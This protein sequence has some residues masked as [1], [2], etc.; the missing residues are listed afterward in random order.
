[1]L[2]PGE[3]GNDVFLQSCAD[4]IYAD[5]DFAKWRA[6]GR[7]PD[8]GN[9]EPKDRVSTAMKNGL[10]IATAILCVAGAA[11]SAVSLQNHFSASQTGYC[12]LN[13]IFNCDLVNRSIY[14]RFMG[15]PVALIGLVGYLLLGGLTVF[16]GRASDRM[17]L[18][19][20]FAGL[21]F[22]SYLAYIEARVLAVWCILCIGSLIAI[23][24]IFILSVFGVARTK[25]QP[26]VLMASV[27]VD[28]GDGIDEI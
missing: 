24:G 28:S 14:A 10:R 18:G 13:E 1:M 8:I 12:D 23:T 27:P 19:A 7:D 9:F 17:R 6:T 4:T 25:E 22:A 2:S 5:L 15:V 21:S 3:Q 20:S 16:P 11:L 26:E